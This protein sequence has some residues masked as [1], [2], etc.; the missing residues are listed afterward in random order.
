MSLDGPDVNPKRYNTS[1]TIAA[2]VGWL[3]HGLLPAQRGEPSN[4][5]KPGTLARL[6]VA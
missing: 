3:G 1:T 4:V 2:R 5:G 6:R